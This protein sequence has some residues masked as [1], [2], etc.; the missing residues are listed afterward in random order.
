MRDFPASV[1]LVG[2]V[3][4]VQAPWFAPRDMG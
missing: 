4:D 2:Y 3:S 1:A